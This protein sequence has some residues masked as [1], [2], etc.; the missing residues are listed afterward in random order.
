MRRTLC[1]AML[2][3]AGCARHEV[4][5]RRLPTGAALDPAGVSVPLGSMPQ[6][7][8]FSPDST[9]L[10]AV[11]SGY[12]EQGIQ[13]IDRAS[14]RVVQTL[15]Q[16]AAFVG[17]CFSPT[18]DRLFVSGGN[19]DVVYAYAWRADSAALADSIVLGPPP[20]EAGGRAY[21]SGLACSP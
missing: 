14:R 16:P 10:V 6:R 9:R 2:A 18:G 8:L 7:L 17:A 11:L 20:G 15:V 1:L 3:L 19:R 5:S 21:P 13:V 4:D 12:R